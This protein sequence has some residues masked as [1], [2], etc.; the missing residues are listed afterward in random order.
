MRKTIFVFLIIIITSAALYA[1]F[2]DIFKKIRPMSK[3]KTESGNI[4]VRGLD[5]QEDAPGTSRDWKAL[6][7]IEKFKVSDAEINEFIKSGNLKK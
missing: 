1:G 3:R 5:E 2:F 6:E 7:R 4:G